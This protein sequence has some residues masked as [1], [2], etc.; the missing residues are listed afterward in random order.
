[1]SIDDIQVQNI[2]DEAKNVIEY[3]EYGD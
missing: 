1:M 2:L 3:I